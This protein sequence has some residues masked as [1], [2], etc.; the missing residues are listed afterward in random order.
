MP[1]LAVGSEAALSK[2]IRH[3]GVSAR[4]YRTYFSGYFGL[5]TLTMSLTCEPVR[6]SDPSAIEHNF[7]APFS[8]QL[9]S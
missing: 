7:Q 3:T 2:S 8:G 4:L 9:T 6:L 1:I 5:L